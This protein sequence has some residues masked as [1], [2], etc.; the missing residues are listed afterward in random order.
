MHP[1][2]TPAQAP[3]PLA[4]AAGSAADVAFNL[5]LRRWRQLTRPW[6]TKHEKAGKHMMR[7]MYERGGK[8]RR[9]LKKWM[10]QYERSLLRMPNPPEPVEDQSPNASGS[11][12]PGGGQ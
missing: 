2:T 7:W 4:P 5:A 3:T 12:T 9:R 11:A 10:R 8:A 1:D 6:W